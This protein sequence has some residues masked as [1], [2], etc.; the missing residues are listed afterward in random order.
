MM[1][2]AIIARWSGQVFAPTTQR[3]FMRGVVLFVFL[4]YLYLWPVREAFWGEK[5]LFE[6]VLRTPGAWPLRR[7]LAEFPQWALPVYYLLLVACLWCLTGFRGARV[8]RGVV[9][10]ASV[11]LYHAAPPVFNA[12]LMLFHVLVFFTLFMHPWA[13]SAEATLITNTAFF[14][15]RVQLVLVYALAGG[16]KLSG[17]MWLNGVAVYHGLMLERYDGLGLASWFSDKYTLLKGMNYAALAYQVLFPF[18]IWVRRI[19]VYLL[20]AAFGF[21]GFIAIG[22]DLL[23][24]GLGMIMAYVVFFPEAWSRRL[25]DAMK[26]SSAQ[27]RASTIRSTE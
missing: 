26:F 14:A 20:L 5:A 1:I 19:R 4:L 3:L 8:A 6:P 17:E 13:R 9:F 24:F 21:H 15:C 25:A 22:F 7:V 2:D 16:Y 10:L 11:A 23:D 27:K 18:L 12:V